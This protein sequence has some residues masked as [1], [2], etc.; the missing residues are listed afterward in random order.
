MYLKNTSYIFVLNEWFGIT[1]K[2][3]LVVSCLV[4]VWLFKI[5]DLSVSVSLY[6]VHNVN[7]NILNVWQD[8]HAHDLT[9]W[10]DREATVGLALGR[11]GISAAIEMSPQKSV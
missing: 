1:I 3:G 6:N 4:C 7:G 8:I 9:C 2:Q 5:S 10:E 11:G